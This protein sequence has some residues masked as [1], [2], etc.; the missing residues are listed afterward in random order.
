MQH[1]TGVRQEAGIGVPS[2]SDRLRIVIGAGVFVVA[3]TVAAHVTVPVPWSPV[4]VTLQPLVVL[5]AGA[6]LGPVPAAAAMATYV[7]LGAAGAPVFAGGMSGLAWLVGPTGGYL[8]AFPV[9]ALAVGL[10]AGSGTTV[11]TLLGMLTGLVVIYLGGVSQLIVL[12]GLD[13][14]QAV[15]LGVLPFV[16]GDLVKVGLALILARALRAGGLGR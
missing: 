16:A 14:A 5:L 4:P 10:I 8:M 2:R 9:A 13:P 6:V 12:T 3:M 15:S 1:V 11:R 7:L